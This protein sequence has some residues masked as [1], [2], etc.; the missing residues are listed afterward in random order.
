MA[1]FDVH[2]LINRMAAEFDVDVDELSEACAVYNTT[3]LPMLIEMAS[4]LAA[5]DH[6]EPAIIDYI[7]KSEAL[8]AVFN[9]D[10]AGL[11]ADHD[12]ARIEVAQRVKNQ[13]EARTAL[14]SAFE[15]ITI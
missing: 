5:Q 13:G 6:V 10:G 12:T 2:A 4:R 8:L 7:D 11:S 9:G 15:T 1:D 3:V 14:Q